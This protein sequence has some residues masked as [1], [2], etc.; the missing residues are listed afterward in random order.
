MEKS[1][2]QERISKLN[3]S[4]KA[5]VNY[6]I[7]PRLSN[8]SA[9]VLAAAGS[10][11]TTTLTLRIANLLANVPRMKPENILAVTFT[12]KAAMEIQERVSALF[13]KNQEE[14]NQ[15]WLGTFHNA[16][17]R[18]LRARV[19]SG[20][21]VGVGLS[22]NYQVITPSEQISLLR[23][24]FN[25]LYIPDE[26]EEDLDKKDVKKFLSLVAELINN[27]KEEQIRSKDVP[28]YMHYL[29]DLYNQEKE[30]KKIQTK[31]SNSKTLWRLEFYYKQY[32]EGEYTRAK[33]DNSS[34]TSYKEQYR[35]LV[36]YFADM[37]RQ[38]DIM[39]AQQNMAD[40][41]ELM[42][43]TLE[44]LKDDKNGVK[45]YYS[46]KFKEILVDEFQDTNDIQY[47]IITKLGEKNRNVFVVGDDDQSIYAFRGA[48]PINF[49]RFQ[50]HKLFTPKIFKIEHNYRSTEHILNIA[51]T[52]IQNNTVRMGKNLIPTKELGEPVQYHE[53]Q[54]NKDEAKYIAN[55][56][57]E[58]KNEGKLKNNDHAVAIIY[59]TNAQSR[60]FE[61]ELINKKIPYVVHG[62]LRFF[63]R[64]EIKHAMAWFKIINAAMG[65]QHNLRGLTSQFKRIVNI[66]ARGIGERAM[67]KVDE[68]LNTH[69]EY[70]FIDVVNIAQQ[71]RDN[72]TTTSTTQA[73]NNELFN[74]IDNTT[75]IEQPSNSTKKPLQKEYPSEIIDLLESDLFK[76]GRTINAFASFK[77]V[78]DIVLG[79]TK[80]LFNMTHKYESRQ[81]FM[82]EIQQYIA[83][84]PATQEV[85]T[86]IY[87]SWE[88]SVFY[89]LGQ[90][91][92]NTKPIQ[93][94]SIKTAIFTSFVVHLTGLFNM[95]VQNENLTENPDEREQMQNKY[96]NLNELI[97][98]T[99]DNLSQHSVEGI[100]TLNNMMSKGDEH[101]N[102]I[103]M[104]PKTQ[105]NLLNEFTS[106]FITMSSIGEMHTNRGKTAKSN[107]STSEIDVPITLMTIH[108]SKGLEYDYVFVSGFSQGL[109]PHKNALKNVKNPAKLNNE[110]E[111]ERRL[112]YVAFTR[113]RISLILTHSQLC[114]G[115]NYETSV[116]LPEILQSN[117]L[118]NISVIENYL[119]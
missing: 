69:Q 39:C 98:S 4:Q 29:N 16:C 6:N 99:H 117:N 21:K 14:V 68:F 43:A 85:K 76:T 42:L 45:D 106:E 89:L 67:A 34:F 87:H 12:N 64:E 11:K 50:K 19:K 100:N 55:V 60:I 118:N 24:I 38:Y 28:T 2:L 35:L 111:E 80:T 77:D 58:L 20:Y 109:M 97:Y 22:S 107:N 56:I 13:P 32:N 33:Y 30:T 116:F 26:E 75:P 94:M 57:G 52:I 18:I 110:L 8:Q 112:A 119:N 95:Y 92:P 5:A 113:A 37:Y 27:L 36:E 51:N 15:M 93:L 72:K 71:L 47:Q 65:F 9:I 25:N 62:G 53:F 61:Q 101:F 48:L 105:Y 108:A 88:H 63:E 46:S 82:L 59:R 10:G 81:S 103:F 114:N 83:K 79:A 41:S 86:S 96:N 70:N 73:L 115:E 17:N 23:S 91:G 40:F 84:L 49:Q 44:L 90:M 78:I 54:S 74:Q 3:D 7:K 102:N 66:P 31:V 104:T 1:L